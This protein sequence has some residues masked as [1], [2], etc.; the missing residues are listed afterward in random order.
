MYLQSWS[1][2]IAPNAQASSSVSAENPSQPSSEATQDGMKELPAV[3]AGFHVHLLQFCI[4]LFLE[5][6][7]L[8]I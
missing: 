6:N 7:F 1:T 3:I 8:L 5:I 2:S 4:L